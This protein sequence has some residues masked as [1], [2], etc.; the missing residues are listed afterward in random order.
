V[1]V[2]NDL[3]NPWQ[4]K[5]TLRILQGERIVAEKA[6]PCTVAPL[7]REVLTF[8]MTL[9]ETPGPY[10]LAADLPS[11]VAGDKNVRSLRDF[12]IRPSPAGNI[13]RGKPVTASSSVTVGGVSYPAANAVD[14]ESDTYWS[15]EFA[16]PAW[17]RVDLGESIRIRRVTIDWET[18]YA[19]AF[20]VQVSTDAKAWTDVFK[21]GSGAGGASEI[22]FTPV[23]ARYVRIYGTARGTKWGYAICELMVFRE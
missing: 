1:A 21:T 8:E 6:Q 7:G 9:P 5:V 22:D 13:A 18:A 17:L 4:G 3:D 10:T 12:R 19:K 11:L 15:S 16:D 23:A 2:I 14:G 20:A